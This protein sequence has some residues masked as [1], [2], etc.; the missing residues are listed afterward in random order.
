MSDSLE[1]TYADHLDELTAALEGLDRPGDY[2]T[3]GTI[4]SAP[5]LVEVEGV[6]IISIPVPP[7]QACA[8][9]AAAI[10]APYGRGD[11]T[12][13]DESVRKVRQIAP[14]AIGISGKQWPNA[15]KSILAAATEGLGRPKGSLHAD[16]Y[17][18][19]V[20]EPGGFFLAHRD[21]EKA[22]GMLGT[23]IIILPS[24]HAGGELIVRH[25]GRE[26]CLDLRTCDP[27]ELAYAAFYSDCEH[28]VRPVSEGHR[29]CLVYNLIMTAEKKTAPVPDARPHIKAAAKALR[30][31]RTRTDRSQKIVYLLEH[32]YTEAAL[33]LAALKGP[34]AI[35]AKVLIAAAQAADYIP[36]LAMVHIE[37]S[38]WAEYNGGYGLRGKS[39]SH[40]NDDEFDDDDMDEDFE[41]GEVDSEYRFIA[42]WRD[43]QDTPLDYGKIPLEEGEVLPKGALDNEDPD[44]THF[45]EA[46]GNEGAS[47]ERT[48]LRAAI[49]LWTEDDADLI[50]ASA[51]HEAALTRLEQRV[52]AACAGS[53]AAPAQAAKIAAYAQTNWSDYVWSPKIYARFLYALARLSDPAH[54][55]KHGLDRLGKNYSRACNPALRLWAGAVGPH[56][57]ASIIAVLPKKHS[58][59]TALME[60]WCELAELWKDRADAYDTLQHLLNATF[61]ILGD[62]PEDPYEETASPYVSPEKQREVL[63]PGLF[64]R[65]LHCLENWPEP[66]DLRAFLMMVELNET[67]FPPDDLIL[68]ALED[69]CADTP[70]AI[71]LPIVETLW[72]RCAACWLHR[73]ATPPPPPSNWT[74]PLTERQLRG[75]RAD[76]KDFALDPGKREMRLRL[77]K[78]LRQE[79]HRII[80]SR[81]LDMTH[82]TERQGRPYTLVCTKTRG[83]YER[84]C[85][86]YKKDL[87]SIQRLLRLPA[88]NRPANIPLVAQLKSALRAGNAPET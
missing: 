34:D 56:S 1:I 8:L 82:V 6:G 70:T 67:T 14:S 51:G 87:S 65:F 81:K 84:A 43:A 50:C 9:A 5:P 83:P 60:L 86:Q 41:V 40:W 33:S 55:V 75:L 23:L 76:I 39:W 32:R 17:K 13:L 20:Y 42:Q 62:E 4:D 27:G 74:L 79:I 29:I 85:R 88:A 7:E 73:S 2:V 10:K 49:V 21:T 57:F 48:Y 11:Q 12:L 58:H 78:E 19:L 72:Q 35:R 38:G 46:T 31:W 24:V 47:F 44:E 22:H 54:L 45:S 66:E 16:L 36:H 37:E 15:F 3:S 61:P 28:E 68:P 77:R 18:L 71:K 53:C 64:V 63:E 59:A 30:E 69:V 80:D 26:T 52:D 25:D